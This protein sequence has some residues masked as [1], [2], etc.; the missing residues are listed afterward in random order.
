[1]ETETKGMRRQDYV[2]KAL[3]LHHSGYN[4]A[5]SVAC[6]CSGLT[7]VDADELFRLMEGF[8][9]GM[10]GFSETCGALSG[11]IAI[12]SS[13]TSGGTANP[14]TKAGTYARVRP[15]VSSFREKNG[16]TRCP[17][18]KG[19]TGGPVLRS[20]DGCIEDACNLLLDALGVE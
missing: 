5:Q 9:G 8:G 6:A 13:T 20:C 16:S 7:D 15:I 18:L 12:L 10:G 19:M 14:R 17:E 1:M 4:C 2:D 3:E 11:A